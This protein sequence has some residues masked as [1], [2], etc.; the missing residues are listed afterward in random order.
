MSTETDPLSQE[1]RLAWRKWY[2]AAH[3]LKP[4]EGEVWQE[5]ARRARE[6]KDL[7]AV[8]ADN[9]RLRE[10]DG[11]VECLLQSMANGAFTEKELR[12]EASLIL[13]ARAALE[14]N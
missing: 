7:F 1:A 11:S 9:N 12:N 2:I 14:G 13:K 6:D 5:C 3:G 10:L 8:L 4:T